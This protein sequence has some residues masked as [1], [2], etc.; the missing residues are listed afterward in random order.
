MFYTVVHILQPVS[1]SKTQPGDPQ[2][3][4]ISTAKQIHIT[5]PDFSKVIGLTAADQLV[6]AR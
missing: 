5:Q 1:Y 3:E 6:E 2:S 4:A